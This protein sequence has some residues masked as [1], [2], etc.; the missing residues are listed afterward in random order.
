ME[1]ANP[2]RI[3]LLDAL[4]GLS[5]LFIFV[6]NAIYFSGLPFIPPTE[7]WACATL[8]TDEILLLV[9]FTAVDGKFYSIFS[10]LFAI[11]CALQYHRATQKGIPFKPFF[12][13]RMFW[14]LIIGLVHLC[15]IWL[16]DILTLYAILGFALLWFIDVPDDRLL[17]WAVI[18]IMLPVAN[19][20]FIYESGFDYPQAVEE[21]GNNLAVHLNND[22]KA[23]TNMRAYLL[24]NDWEIFLKTNLSNSFNRW[25][26]LLDE[27]RPFKVFGVFLI[28]LWAG[29]KIISANLLEN[30]SLL[31]KIALWGL[32]FGIAFSSLRTYCLFFAEPD[33]FLALVETIAYALGTVPLAM[34]YAAS[35]ALLYR[36][37]KI[38]LL[39]PAGRMALTNYLMQTFIGIGLFYGIGL[40]LAGKLGFTVVF[41][42][43][44]FVF[45]LQTVL[46]ILWLR[47]FRQGPLEKFWRARTKSQIK[48]AP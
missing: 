15:L 5:V 12:R 42:M 34:G 39:E 22:S 36:R 6:A 29:R 31:K 27:G 14:L 28:G 35:F 19:S 1:Q 30:T 21:I 24:N 33:E 45:G 41:L 9:T 44:L 10:L 13:R 2:E 43:A 7:Q 32:S 26:R 4:R 46:S 16:G 38:S 47:K 3:G 8:P 25:S 40:G 37:K 11:G 17:L 20:V 23:I 18:F 48:V